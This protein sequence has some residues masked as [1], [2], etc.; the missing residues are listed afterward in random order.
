MKVAARGGY[1]RRED[2]GVEAVP[3]SRMNNFK[4]EHEA[5]LFLKFLSH[6]I[7]GGSTVTMC[8]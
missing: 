6:S 2:I 4:T 7:P 1:R 5:T 3:Y 8:V